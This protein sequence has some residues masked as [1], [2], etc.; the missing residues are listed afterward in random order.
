MNTHGEGIRRAGSI[1][2]TDVGGTF[3]DDVNIDIE[4]RAAKI[5]YR[6]SWEP[7]VIGSREL[8]LEVPWLQFLRKCELALNMK[9]GIEIEGA[10]RIHEDARSKPSIWNVFFMWIT[11]TCHAGTVPIGILGAEFGLS[12]HE[13]IA[14]IVA[15]N[16]LGA[17]CTSF[18]GTLGPK[19][20]QSRIINNLSANLP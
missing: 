14:A 7:E 6:K 16:V 12:F 11:V 2:A 9:L 13:S 20:R 5:A 18:C 1:Q 8:V 4:A 15:G 3:D 19:V 10:T 17:L